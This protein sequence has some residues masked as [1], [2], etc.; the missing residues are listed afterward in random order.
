VGQDLRRAALLTV[1]LG[2]LLLAASLMPAAGLGSFPSAGSDAGGDSRPAASTGTA[3]ETP[4]ETATE[5]A[6][7]TDTATS[8]E[9]AT[10]TETD[11]SA[12]DPPD[13]SDGSGSVFTE[14]L[15][16]FSLITFG[17][18]GSTLAAA[19]YAGTVLA[20]STVAG[21][22]VAERLP[23]GAGIRSL[24]TAT[25]AT[26]IGLSGS[27]SRFFRSVGSGADALVAGLSGLTGTVGSIGVG[28]TVVLSR[29]VSLGSGLSAGVGSLFG[30]LGDALSSLTRSGATRTTAGTTK[31][32]SVDARSA[33][34]VDPDTPS[35]PD[36][37][38][39]VSGAWERMTDHIPVS[40]KFAKTPAELR[41]AAIER[42]WPRDPVERLTA[43]FRE[44]RYGSSD[45]TDEHTETAL[46]AFAE[47]RSYWEDDQ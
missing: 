26:L 25:M 33:A 47:L 16:V 24:P 21:P 46:S 22:A 27:L 39:T 3:T 2:A 23:F 12:G 11:T 29:S 32:T 42:D 18:V 1:A 36:E 4:I 41:N 9:P 30:S 40:D 19:G 45:R 35:E 31:A 15:T 20:V 14:L 8:T 17:V 43:V 44:V 28:L 13:R 6:T 7:P 34:G 10:P 37:P 38:T 5:T